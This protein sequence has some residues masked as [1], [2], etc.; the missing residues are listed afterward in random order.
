MSDSLFQLDEK[1]DRSIVP[2]R[3][4]SSKKTINKGK[5]LFF[6]SDSDFYELKN[7]T[8]FS[9]VFNIYSTEPT[10]DSKE[11]NATFGDVKR[12]NASKLNK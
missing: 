9:K 10:A 7:M 8:D 4:S 1:S 5:V 2:Y 3:S 11:D 12:A 6:F